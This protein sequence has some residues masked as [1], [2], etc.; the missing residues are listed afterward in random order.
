MTP[1][2]L[3]EDVRSF[4]RGSLTLQRRLLAFFLL[5]L[6]A[7]M[8]VLFL[9]LIV[10]GVFS[11]GMKESKAF[12]EN[13]LAHISNDINANNGAL[14]VEAIAISKRLTEQIENTLNEQKLSSAEMQDSVE[15]L[16]PILQSCLDILYNALD[17]NKASGAFIILDATVNP[18]LDKAAFSRAGLFLKNIEP[19]AANRSDSA[20]RYLR[21]PAQIA[22]QNGLTVLPQWQME[23]TVNN[24]D[25]FHIVKDIAKNSD[26]PLSRLYH[27]SPQSIIEN[28]YQKSVLLAIPLITRDGTVLGVCGF[29]LSA[30]LFKLQNSPDNS[31]YTRVFSMFAPYDG[32]SLDASGALFAGCYSAAPDEFSGKI[33]ANPQGNG[34]YGFKTSTGTVFT[35]LYK[36]INLYPTDSAYA[37]DGWAVAVM[38]PERDLSDFVAA[39]NSFILILLVLLLVFSIVTATLFSRRYISPV[40]GALK[41]MQQD[42]ATD[43]KKTN[44]Q[45]IDDLFEFLAA[46]DQ[47]P[48]PA[49]QKA[50]V[51]KAHTT[52]LFEAFVENISNLSPAE[53]AVFNLYREGHTAKQIADILCL[54]IN[55]IKTHNK[56]IYMKLNV[57]SRKELMVYLNMLKE[58]G[59]IE[60]DKE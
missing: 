32:E 5:Y 38:I 1:F 19:N 54:S 48:E 56:R 44:I 34:V 2:K 23:F 60:V 30:M 53:R 37:D 36:P 35:G 39:E 6:V 59:K 11:A 51:S 8:S 52:A 29:E 21:G 33:L 27:W 9:I 10:S 49:K 28:D 14:S 15:C 24:G 7:V 4:W 12:L 58:R 3:L 57:A 26:L 55:T 22:R 50:V 47:H 20:I 17:K 42:D 31:V 40:V 16:N 43:F 13:E 41:Q 18:A 46:Q 45:E 25:I